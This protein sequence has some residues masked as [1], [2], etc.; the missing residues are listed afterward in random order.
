MMNNSQIMIRTFQKKGLR[1]VKNISVAFIIALSHNVVK[2]RD[3]GS[4]VEAVRCGTE[5]VSTKT[6]T[7][8]HKGTM[9]FPLARL[10]WQI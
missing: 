8:T 9:C 4:A 10:Q 2:A 7:H 1:K 5:V 3:S 6:H